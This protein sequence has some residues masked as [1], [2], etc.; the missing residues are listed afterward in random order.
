MNLQTEEDFMNEFP[1]ASQFTQQLET[2][3]SQLP[4]ILNDYQKYYRFYNKNPEN[5]EYQQMFQNIKGNLS[6][7]NSKLFILSND[8]QS[9]INKL[10]SKL[11]ALDVLIKREKKK[12]ND[13]KKQL[14]ITN[15]E[16]SDILIDEYKEIYQSGYLR[17]W[18]LFL[19]IL[20]VMGTIAKIYQSKIASTISNVTNNLAKT[21]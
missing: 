18:A 10:N 6:N 12:N 13:L 15:V 11:F 7:I 21:T 9:N 19:S 2:L 14:G 16:V 8:V 1:S 17:N 3:Q 20:I 4:S 5:Q